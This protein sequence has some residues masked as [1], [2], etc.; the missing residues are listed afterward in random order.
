MKTAEINFQVKSVRQTTE[1]IAALTQSYGGQV[2]HHI[3][4]STTGDSIDVRKSDDSVMRVTLVN[5]TAEMTVKIP[6]ASLV[7]FLNKVAQMGIRVND[8]KMDVTDKSLDYLS[9]RLKLKNQNELVDAQKKTSV[10]KKDP[11][12][13][14]AFKNNMVDQQINNL[15]IDDSVKLSTVMLSFYE[16]NAVNKHMMADNNL[17]DY[18]QPVSTRFGRS[19]ETGWNVFVEILIGISN[20]WILIPIGLVIWLAISY[21]KRNAL[22][23]G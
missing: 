12:N 7:G 14:L 5:S 18:Q 1:Q 19:F 23:K 11:D 10:N 20:F 8:Q 9:T 2:I 3:M 22:V 6:P 16:S 15:K 17:A 13:L 4:R 21:F